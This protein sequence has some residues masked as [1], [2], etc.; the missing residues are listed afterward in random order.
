MKEAA[1]MS[2]IPDWFWQAVETESK[3]GSVKVDDV[4]ISYRS[5]SEPGNPGLLFVHGH[6]AHSRW[7][8]FIAPKYREDFHTVALDLSGM[9]DS[10]H[11]D[12]Y[13]TDL[14]AAE[15]VAVADAN[16]MPEDT[17]VVAHSFG[18]IMSL[19]TFATHM[20]RFKGLILV[21]SG[22]KH[23]DDE[24]PQD[25]ERWSK[26]KVYPTPEI[27][28]SRFRLQ[29]PQQCE[30]DYLVQYIA[31]HSV[32]AVDDGFVWKFDEELNSRM[33]YTGDTAL[34]LKS[35]TGNCALIYGQHSKSF[36]PKSVAYMQELQPALEVSEIKDAQHHLF[37]D[38]PIA[39]MDQLSAI[40][41]R[42]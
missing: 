26:P 38:Q 24:K 20:S 21:D 2:E 28:R 7:W 12:S 19:R 3:T 33:Q 37:L 25:V 8:D 39:F 30:N 32:D 34:D 41:D 17:I 5:W 9:G 22:V 40:L 35:L 10:D 6:N 42:W 13:S 14:F 1:L 36:G 15:I 18:G 27:A 31:R 23:A 29:P 11:R 16:Q 4:D